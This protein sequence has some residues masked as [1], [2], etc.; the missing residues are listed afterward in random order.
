VPRLLTIR[1]AVY[2]VRRNFSTHRST[3][4]VDEITSVNHLDK[5]KKAILEQKK[6][7]SKNSINNIKMKPANFL[8][9]VLN[10]RI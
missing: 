10:I 2:A 9:N 7:N 6:N 8:F 3:A 4:G 1:H 5:Q